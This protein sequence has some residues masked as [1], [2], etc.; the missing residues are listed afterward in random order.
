MHKQLLNLNIYLMSYQE[1]N[2][3]CKQK[4]NIFIAGADIKKLK[5]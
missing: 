5:I 3:N 4:E 1:K 2:N